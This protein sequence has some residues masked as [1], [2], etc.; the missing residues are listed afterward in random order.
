M[1]LQQMHKVAEEH[2]T[3]PVILAGDFNSYPYTPPY[4][5]TEAGKLTAGN[6]KF[7]KD[8]IAKQPV[9]DTYKYLAKTKIY[10][11]LV[12]HLYLYI[13]FMFYNGK[14]IFFYNIFNSR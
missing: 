2:G 1:A 3:K 7:M 13:S 14:A 10:T 4:K 12:M 8:Y 11:S 9:I 6:L 5:F